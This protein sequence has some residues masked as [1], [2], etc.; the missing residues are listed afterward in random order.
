MQKRLWKALGLLLGVCVLT[1]AL[2][3]KMALAAGVE[4]DGTLKVSYSDAAAS[5]EGWSY[6]GD[7]TLTLNG[8]DGGSIYLTGAMTVYLE[9]DNHIQATY[10]ITGD[11]GIGPI[12]LINEKHVTM[13]TP[14]I[15]DGMPVDWIIEDDVPANLTIV[16]PG[17]LDIDV[18]GQFDGIAYGITGNNLTIKEGA[19]VNIVVDGQ[20]NNRMGIDLDNYMYEGYDVNYAGERALTV[21]E[22]S[23]S[24]IAESP[25]LVYDIVFNNCS[26]YALADSGSQ[27]I[28]NPYKLG[29][30][31]LSNVRGAYIDQYEATGYKFLRSTATERVNEIRLVPGEGVDHKPGWAKENGAWYFYND[32]GSMLTNSRI[33]VNYTDYYLGKDG[34]LVT[35]AG[36]VQDDIG[37]FY[38]QS[39]GAVRK[40]QGWVTAGSD[41]YYIDY[42]GY[43]VTSDWVLDFDQNTGTL[44]Q[45]YFGAN[46]KLVIN[47]T[48]DIDGI[49]YTFKNA[50]LVDQ[51]EI[52]YPGVV[53]GSCG[54]CM[55][56][57]DDD[58]VLTIYPDP[59]LGD[60]GVLEHDY[61]YKR[62]SFGVDF[63]IQ[64]FSWYPYHNKI[65]KAVVAEGVSA[66]SLKGLFLNCSKLEEVDLSNL[67]TSQ[68]TDMSYMLFNC[69]KLTSLDISG[70]DT[71]QVTD[72]SWMFEATGLTSLDLSG[73]DTSN[74]TNMEGM[75]AD[76]SSL[77]TIDMTG[78]NTSRVTNMGSMFGSRGLTSLDLSSFDTSNVTTM[79]YM[80]SAPNLTVLTVGDG[81]I[82]PE[83]DDTWSAPPGVSW[84]AASDGKSYWGYELAHRVGADT[85]TRTGEVYE[86][87]WHKVDNT[88]YYFSFYE[89]VTN[90]FVDANGTQYYL[91]PD[92]KIVTNQLV[93]QYG[94]VYYVGS[95]GKMIT[96]QWK[97]VGG[98][99]YYFTNAGFA[100][101]DGYMYVN[102]TWY[103]FD[104]EG[105]VIT[106]AWTHIDSSSGPLYMYVGSD[107]KPVKNT[108]KQ[109]NGQWYYL[110]SDGFIVQSGWATYNGYYLFLI[111]Y[112]PVKNNWV[113]IDGVDY[114]FNGS[115]YCTRVG[116]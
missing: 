92:G 84:T 96:D 54:T 97:Q 106:N 31:Q 78:W 22:A 9:G 1:L 4:S 67:D 115:G 108:W 32:D 93:K 28:G 68:V 72:M 75:F 43:L 61:V 90:S 112:V 95:D 101:T 23:L 104:S 49:R 7:H 82:Q 26:V 91:G 107:G 86:S 100:L 42:R 3:P 24:I 14:V 19:T 111:E 80:F 46:G 41:Y 77:A 27:A 8:Y 44:N 17:T 35:S 110:G 39:G 53:F 58:G 116:R 52:E 11:V 10:G 15:V 21:D 56:E 74:V 76:N 88:W 30:I 2:V 66:T 81:F 87:G 85:Y 12:G 37:W 113:R 25:M 6:D 13:P 98:Y 16:G 36:W 73:F 33:T 40:N 65:V 62:G 47:G 5:G 105:H 50:K 20:F 60:A 48:V 83:G 34:R 55:W 29:S 57:I 64:T 94:M 103:F 89:L 71:S 114:Y 59:K 109:R 79:R 18:N 38:I 70:F 63:S 99:W 45:Y 69:P 51:Q 102:E